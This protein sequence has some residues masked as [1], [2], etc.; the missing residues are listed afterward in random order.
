ME[1]IRSSETMATTWKATDVVFWIVMMWSIVVITCRTRSHGPEY[2][3][4][5]IHRRE[6]LKS[7]L[8]WLIPLP[9]SAERLVECRLKI[10]CTSAVWNH[11]NS[12]HG[13]LFPKLSL[14]NGLRFTCL[15]EIQTSVKNVSIIFAEEKFYGASKSWQGQNDVTQILPLCVVR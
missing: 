2:N 9:K 13:P 4:G 14:Y 7:R 1:A 6:N 8:K 12:T 5:H 15:K 3:E 10:P 11:R